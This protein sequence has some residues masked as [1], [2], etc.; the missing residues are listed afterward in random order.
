MVRTSSPA[1]CNEDRA[2]SSIRGF[3]TPSSCDTALKLRL[4][5]NSSG[6]IQAWGL[7]VTIAMEKTHRT[8]FGLVLADICQ[9][10]RHQTLERTFLDLQVLLKQLFVELVARGFFQGHLRR[11]RCPFSTSVRLEHKVVLRHH[12]LHCPDHVYKGHKTSCKMPGSGPNSASFSPRLREYNNTAESSQNLCTADPAPNQAKGTP[13]LCMSL[14]Q[15]RQSWQ[16]SHSYPG[17]GLACK[18]TSLKQHVWK[19]D[20]LSDGSAEPS[21]KTSMWSGLWAAVQ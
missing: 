20:L 5:T 12:S 8:G 10:L 6:V 17:N 1:C 15:T 7:S 11:L 14:S 4:Q 19:L 18:I 16:L 2:S 3:L 9:E 21:L 13:R